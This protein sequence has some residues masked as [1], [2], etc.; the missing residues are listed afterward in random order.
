M[1]YDPFDTK[2]FPD[3]EPDFL[4]SGQHHGWVRDLDFDDTSHSVKYV[5]RQF[6]VIDNDDDSDDPD[7][8]LTVNGT[9][10]SDY[11]WV[12]ENTPTIASGDEG[13]YAY[14]LIVVRSSDNA[15]K[16]LETGFITLYLT[17]G[18]RRT[19]AEIMVAK[20]NS[21]LQGRADSDVMNYTIKSR[22]ISKMS[23]KELIEWRNYYLEEINRTGGS[24]VP[25]DT[26]VRAKTN[27]V[28][29]RFT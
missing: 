27:T 3:C 22:S 6:E 26:R 19:H 14:D 29:V 11:G 5:F 21:I 7:G 23:P 15:E 8:N 1:S 12:F 28:T 18:D 9:Y 2:Y 20:I 10:N 25:G 17:D 24:T 13:E 16:I 4:V